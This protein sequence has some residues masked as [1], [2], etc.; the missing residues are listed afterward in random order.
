MLQPGLAGLMFLQEV[1]F[2]VVS[3]WSQ[4]GY[5]AKGVIIVLGLLVVFAI[6]KAILKLAR[7]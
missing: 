6:G 7:G 5:L 4:M 2:D 3:M 1:G